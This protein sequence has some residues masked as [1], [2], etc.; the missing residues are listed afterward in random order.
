MFSR[1][2]SMEIKINHQYLLQHKIGNGSFG[3]IY[4]GWD[5]TNNKSIAIK[6]EPRSSNKPSYLYRE[7]YIYNLL[8]KKTIKNTS[9]KTHLPTFLWCGHTKKFDFLVLPL[10]GINLRT[11]FKQNNKILPD[12]SNITTQTFSAIKSLHDYNILHRDIKPENF[13]FEG[14][15]LILIDYG[16]SITKNQKIK[17]TWVGTPKFTSPWIGNDINYNTRD[18]LSSWWIMMFWFWKKGNLPWTSK[19]GKKKL[20]RSETKRELHSLQKQKKEWFIKFLDNNGLNIS[21]NLPSWF[22]NKG[23]NI[24]QDLIANKNH[25]LVTL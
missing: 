10:Y 24:H 9:K 25:S 7:G 22:I 2:T 12:W 21:G 14:N 18:D 5:T 13:V 1:N 15:N 3:K 19:I 20:S 17:P 23:T 8:R 16:L 11:Y 6:I 4:Q